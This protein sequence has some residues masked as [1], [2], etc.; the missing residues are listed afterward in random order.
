M[1]LSN[2]QQNIRYTSHPTQKPGSAQIFICKQEKNTI[3][4]CYKITQ[5]IIHN[6]LQVNSEYPSERFVCTLNTF[7]RKFYVNIL[8]S[9]I[10][11][12]REIDF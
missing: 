2:K 11:S 8:T 9:N 4:E 6:C 3:L 10:L 12:D 5:K 7:S 1:V